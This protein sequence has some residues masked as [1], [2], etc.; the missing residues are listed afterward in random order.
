VLEPQSFCYIRVGGVYGYQMVER[1]IY[2]EAFN[3]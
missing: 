2:T 3:L 1:D